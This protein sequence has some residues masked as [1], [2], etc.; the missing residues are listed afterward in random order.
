MLW[1]WRPWL[2]SQQPHEIQYVLDILSLETY[3]KRFGIHM[4][5]LGGGESEGI[6][7]YEID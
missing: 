3:Q 7:Q 1:S 2:E 5:F 6:L 4:K